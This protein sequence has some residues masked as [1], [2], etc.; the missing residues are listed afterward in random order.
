MAQA[1]NEDAIRSV[2][3]AS[4][5]GQ[6]DIIVEDLRSLLPKS[7]A[8]TLLEPSFVAALRSEWE[9]ST[10]SSILAAKNGGGGAEGCS[11]E[12]CIALLS[13][14]MD[15]YVASKF[16]S[17]GVRAAHSV[18]ASSGGGDDTLTIATYAERVDLHNHHAGSWRGRYSICPATGDLSGKITI[19]AHTF[20]NGGNVQ[21]H[22]DISLDAANVGACSLSGGSDEQS[23]WASAVVRQIDAWEEEMAMQK[24]SDMYESM[25]NTYLKSL[26]R[27]M[28]ITRTKMEWNVMAHRVVQTL[29]EGHDKEKFKH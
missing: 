23:L 28:P 29:G 4:P 26:R 25:G 7:S 13:K 9:A 10:G 18:T 11:S 27:V 6:F 3:L 16:S 1:V 19:R 15:D 5:P 2:L 8:P 14:S 12:W 24:L 21:L 17:P 20:E 22:S